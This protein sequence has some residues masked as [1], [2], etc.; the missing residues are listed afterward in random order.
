MTSLLE[1]VKA[2]SLVVVQLKVR[3]GCLQKG[4]CW[5][6]VLGGVTTKSRRG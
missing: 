2:L 6:D 4:G 1:K 5:A 3:Y